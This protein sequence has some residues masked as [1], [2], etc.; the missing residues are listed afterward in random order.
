[1][2]ESETVGDR[3][4]DSKKHEP[5]S[6]LFQAPLW[7]CHFFLSLRLS[8]EGIFYLSLSF[9]LRPHF[10]SFCS[11]LF[12]DALFLF[13]FSFM[14]LFLQA[15]WCFFIVP[16]FWSQG[17]FCLFLAVCIWLLYIYFLY[18]L[19]PS[20]FCLTL[21]HFPWLLS[22]YPN[23]TQQFRLSSSV[24]PLSFLHLDPFD[25]VPVCSFSFPPSLLLLLLLPFVCFLSIVFFSSFA[26]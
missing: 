22:P 15:L 13:F 5:C 1:M 19:Y 3:G 18:F 4:E 12:Y 23:F 21:I 17:S 16:G 25:Q 20:V 10:F 7:G 24:Q 26:G 14:P 9:C 2:G 8:F 11:F 6:K